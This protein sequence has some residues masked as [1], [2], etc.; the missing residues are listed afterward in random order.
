MGSTDRPTANLLGALTVAL[1]D[2]IEE[3]LRGALDLGETAAAALVS[4][5]TRPGTSVGELAKVIG[6]EQSTTVRV[7][8][9]LETSGLVVRAQAADDARRVEL[10]LTEEG[11][12]SSGRI[13]EGRHEVLAGAL[14]GLDD[15]SRARLH[16]LLDR[17]LASMASSRER[18]RNICRLCDHGV[19]RGSSCP[20]GRAF[21]EGDEERG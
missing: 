21:V 10:R 6:K 16:E 13:L 14:R 8:D 7:V 2:E 9:R 11:R 17:L 4:I 20:V 3:S 18:A 1:G 15:G 5:G 12:R 19:C